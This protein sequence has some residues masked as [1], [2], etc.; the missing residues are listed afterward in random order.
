MTFVS[1]CGSDVHV[2]T[3]ARGAR[4]IPQSHIAHTYNSSKGVVDLHNMFRQGTLS[5]EGAYRT[6]APVRRLLTTLIGICITDAYL[7]HRHRWGKGHTSFWDF[8]FFLA[9]AM[10][11]NTADRQGVSTRSSA[12]PP[13]DV[14]ES[15]QLPLHLPM[16]LRQ[17]PYYADGHAKDTRLR[18]RICKKKTGYC[19]RECSKG[20]DFASIVPVCLPTPT[21]NCFDVHVRSSP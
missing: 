12:Q 20:A 3:A 11:E 5:L 6:K 1:T 2:N 17:H 9:S 8:R 4:S 7:L 21:E 19:C 14:D 18:C 13:P 15:E 16:L 10:A